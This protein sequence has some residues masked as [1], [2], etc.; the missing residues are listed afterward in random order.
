MSIIQTSDVFPFIHH[1]KIVEWDIKSANTSLMRKYHLCDEDTIASFERMKKKDREIAVGKYSR[2]TP[3]F[4]VALE[5]AFDDI[6]HLFLDTNEID[7]RYDCT[8]VRKDAIFVRSHDVKVSKFDEVQFIPKNEYSGRLLIPKY[9]FYYSQKSID[10]K[11]INDN[12]LHLHEDGTLAFIKTVFENS[13]DL[14]RLYTFI[15]D[16]CYAYK[17]RE[18]PFNAYRQFNSESLF[19]V[20]VLDGIIDMEEISDEYIEYADIS[21]NYINI[22]LEVLKILIR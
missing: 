19:K 6:I 14:K 10:V 20:C 1:E 4:S 16:Y 2:N 5:K 7:I 12:A 21:F 3:G 9:E 17:M 8:A 15:K 11:G 18:L 13:R 22:I